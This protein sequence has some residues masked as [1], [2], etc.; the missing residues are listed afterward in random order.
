VNFSP[1]QL[2]SVVKWIVNAPLWLQILLGTLAGTLFIGFLN[3][4]ALYNYAFRFGARIPIEGVSELNLALSAA[5][6]AFLL[7]SI[8]CATIGYGLLLIIAKVFHCFI[9]AVKNHWQ[10]SGIKKKLAMLPFLFFIL[11]YMESAMYLITTTTFVLFLNQTADNWDF[12]LFTVT[13][14]FIFSLLAFQPLSVKGFL[15]MFTLLLVLMVSTAMFHTQMYS[16]FL[17]LIRYGGGISIV[18]QCNEPNLCP[19]ANESYL[20]LTTSKAYELYNPRKHSF[21]ELAREKVW[22]IEYQTST[23]YALPN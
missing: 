4:F 15:G 10:G 9:V 18:L 2:Q 13:L 19:A 3:N 16:K 1:V 14:L 23:Q 17:R 21:L 6:F 12:V 22:G 11:I 5:S 7:V 8:S 20:F